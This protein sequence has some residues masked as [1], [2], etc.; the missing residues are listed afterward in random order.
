MAFDF[1]G[2]VDAVRE[3]QLKFISEV[4]QERGFE[5]CEVAIEPVGKAGDNFIA[6]VK[7]I[8]INQNGK[9]F[10]MIAKLGPLMR[11]FMDITGMFQNEHVAYTELFP[12]FRELQKNSGL[13]EEDW[14]RHAKCYGTFMEKPDEV[15]LLEDLKDSNF[16]I[17]N[18]FKPMSIECV[19]LVLKNFAV[20]HSLSYALKNQEPEKF[21]EI[22]SMLVEIYDV[23]PEAQEMRMKFGLKMEN[24]IVDKLTDK[25]HK[26]AF[27][28][29]MSNFM[30][31]SKIPKKEKGSKSS[32]IQQ[33]DGWTN[34]IMFTFEVSVII[35]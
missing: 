31:L 19:K 28:G 9:T 10:K 13:P 2:E 15:I 32:I 16:D 22:S 7:R 29:T 27:V 3:K 6:S 33:G 25:K 30:E 1:V 23:P 24:D 26:E 14:F 17:L 20:Y 8:V 5:K 21:N 34:N 11:D 12:K 4:L 35:P 18:R